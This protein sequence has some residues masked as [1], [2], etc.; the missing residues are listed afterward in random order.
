M[1]IVMTVDPPPPSAIAEPPDIDSEPAPKK[2]RLGLYRSSSDRY[3]AGV[4]GGA[5]ERL[6]LD[7]LF[8]RL[9]LVA[10]T[11][12]LSRDGGPGAIPLIAYF[13]AWLT[14]GTRSDRSLLRRIRVR[15]AQQEIFGAAAVLA[16]A[17]LVLSRPELLWAGALFGIAVAMLTDRRE[18]VAAQASTFPDAAAETSTYP[19]PLSSSERA[20]TWGRS[21]RGTPHFQREPRVRGPRRPSRSPKLWPLTVALLFTYAL[22]WVLLD[23]FLDSGIDPGVAV[24]GALLIIGAVMLLAGWRGRAW[25]TLLLLL[26]LVPLWIAFTLAGVDR[27]PDRPFS[28]AALESGDLIQASQGYGGLLVDLRR[29]ELP[30]TGE[31]TAEVGVTA[32]QI[33]VWVPKGADI[34]ITGDIGLGD[35]QVF[36]EQGWSFESETL[37]NWGLNRSYPALGRECFETYTDDQGLGFT[38]EISQVAVA[39]SATPDEVADAIEAAGY[40]RPTV[41]TTEQDEVTFNEQGE[42]IFQTIG[43]NLWTYQ[44]NNNG[45]LCSPEPPPDNPLLI[46]IDATLGIGNLK[47]HRV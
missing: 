18:A 29:S 24:N 13:V 1:L 3:V 35:L 26:P 16:L 32:G 10:A 28:A 20:I 36:E 25:L 6:D 34:R 40:P 47:V 30:A 19:S 31:I 12:F 5:A 11:L 8:I 39:Q 43:R 15:T 4:A 9:G 23:N 2:A 7:P 46:T 14:L 42:Q 33:D 38:A 22:A 45:G 27:V 17:L 21:L 44:A 37:A 41:E